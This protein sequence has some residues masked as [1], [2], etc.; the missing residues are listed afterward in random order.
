MPSSEWLGEE[1]ANMHRWSV[2][3]SRKEDF[4]PTTRAFETIVVWPEDFYLMKQVFGDIFCLVLRGAGDAFLPCSS[5]DAQC[6]PGR[7]MRIVA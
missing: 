5:D 7:A 2:V 4:D 3:I 6:R 1:Q